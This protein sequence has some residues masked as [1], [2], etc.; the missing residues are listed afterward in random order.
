[1]IGFVKGSVGFTV[2]HPRSGYVSITLGVLR[3]NRIELEPA[4]FLKLLPTA[5]ENWVK[6]MS[7]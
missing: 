2:G 5:A 4:Y 1:M 7:K 3:R 6:H